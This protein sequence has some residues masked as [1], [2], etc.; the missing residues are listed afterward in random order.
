MAWFSSTRYDSSLIQSI[1]PRQPVTPI[2]QSMPRIALIF[3]AAIAL[4]YFGL[5]VA[6]FLSQR[7]LLY[8]P[9][10]RSLA[11]NAPTLTFPVDG[12]ELLITVRPRD[13]PKA[14]V[15]FGGNGEDV[16]YSLPTLTA[17]FPEHALY[18][19]NYRGYGGSSGKSSEAVIVADA[20]ALFDKVHAEHSEIVLMGRSLGSGVAI[21]LAIQRPASRLVLVTPYNSIQELAARRYPLFPVRL[22]MLDKFESWKYAS[23]VAI[24]TLL[25]GAEQDYTVPRWS[26]DLLFTHFRSGIATLSVI[27][28]TN[29]NSISESPDY[30]AMLKN[31]R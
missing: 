8:F 26:T 21:H 28:G 31:L 13:G 2:L 14:L 11:N 9:P 30:I 5:C 18:L 19:M 3:S 4:V 15:Y 1:P 7:S 24:P 29:H 6:L 12:A 10:P 16:S 22:L 20:L 17:A 25:I 27:P 23:Q